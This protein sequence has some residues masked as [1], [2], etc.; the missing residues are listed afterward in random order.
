MSRP[1]WRGVVVVV[2][3]VPD[4]RAMRVIWEV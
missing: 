4:D 1:A 2:G 3:L